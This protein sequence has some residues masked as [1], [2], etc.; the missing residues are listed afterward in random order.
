ME[1]GETK[2]RLKE[3]L[4]T[5]RM[6]VEAQTKNSE[7]KKSKSGDG[8][9]PLPNV[10]VNPEIGGRSEETKASIKTKVKTERCQGSSHGEGQV[11]ETEKK[12]HFKVDGEVAEEL[13]WDC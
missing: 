2:L 12:P 8:A 4:A 9:K 3:A 6:L 13:Y 1:L 10:K 11:Y 5:N 7:K